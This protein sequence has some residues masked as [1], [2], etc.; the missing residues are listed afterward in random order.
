M[1]T[2]KSVQAE[3]QVLEGSYTVFA[4]STAVGQLIQGEWLQMTLSAGKIKVTSTDGSFSAT[5]VRVIQDSAFC[6]FGLK[7]VVPASKSHSYREN[8]EI[9][10]EPNRLRLVN[11]VSM[12][13]YLEGVIESE[14]GSGRHVEYYKVQAL[15]SRTYA[16]QNENRHKKEGFELCDGVHCQAYHN[17]MKHSPL[18][19]EAVY[20]TT[21]EFIVDKENKPLTTYFHANCGGQTSDA[22][23]VWN[24]SVPYC[25]SF[26]DTFCIHTKQATWVKYIHKGEWSDFLQKEYGYPVYDTLFGDLAFSFTQDQRKAFFIHPSFGIP[27]RDLREKFN[28]KST[29][30]D[31]SLAGDQVK[32][33][34]RGFGHGIGLC[35]EGAMEMAKRGYS[36]RQIAHFYFYGVHIVNMDRLKFFSQESELN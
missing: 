35:Q 34:G 23:Y 20:A 30:F 26:I 1:R 24:T 10:A 9:T 16:I 6:A 21:G 36:Y 29:F 7:S 19:H 11:L 25:E 17:M 31:V 15:M 27:L 8:I 14:G 12:N 18:I 4:D 3:L 28:L 2:V 5:I 32:I 22:A 13:S 33:E